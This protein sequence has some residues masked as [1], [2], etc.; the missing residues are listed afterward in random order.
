MAYE[1]CLACGSSHLS[2]LTSV[3]ETSHYALRAEF[4]LK[5][6]PKGFLANEDASVQLDRVCVCADC[7]YAALFASTK[8]DPAA[9]VGE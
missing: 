6:P 2:P 3:S 7:G 4:R 8:F 1:R 9:I 5:T